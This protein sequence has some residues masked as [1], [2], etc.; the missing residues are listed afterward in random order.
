MTFALVELVVILVIQWGA[1][2][3]R[4]SGGGPSC[5]LFHHRLHC[6]NYHYPAAL[7]N[8]IISYE[9]RVFHTGYP[10]DRTAYI[11]QPS[12]EVDALWEDL[13]QGPIQHLFS[14]S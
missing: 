12:P 2:Y 13:L 3:Q 5:A 11:G 1:Y 6:I 9:S 7:I 14:Y 10:G 4:G 8:G